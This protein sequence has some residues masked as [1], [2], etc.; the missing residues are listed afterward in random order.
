MVPLVT[1]TYVSLDGAWSATVTADANESFEVRVSGL[2]ALG[3]DN[4]DGLATLLAASDEDPLRGILTSFGKSFREDVWFTLLFAEREEEDGAGR[5]LFGRR[6]LS[7]DALV[8]IGA[9]RGIRPM[10]VSWWV[11]LAVR[12]PGDE[13]SFD[14]AFWPKA[15]RSEEDEDDV[16][17]EGLAGYRDRFAPAPES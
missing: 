17:I 13:S 14:P 9:A 6:Y 12:A 8:V 11:P 2:I 1:C 3:L 10:L 7:G 16:E 4:G 5:R 15:D